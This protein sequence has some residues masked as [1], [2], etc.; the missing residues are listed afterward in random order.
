MIKLEGMSSILMVF[1]NIEDKSS[2]ASQ[3]SLRNYNALRCSNSV[4]CFNLLDH[5]EISILSKR[6]NLFFGRYYALSRENE[7]KI[8]ELCKNTDIVCINASFYGKLSKKI[9]QLFPKIKVITFFQNCEYK[10]IK[11]EQP[12]NL[13]AQ[14]VIKKNEEWACK[15]SDKIIVLNER[16]K[17]IIQKLYGR[18]ADAIIPISFPNKQI[19]FNKSEIGSPPT[20]LFLGSNF[21]ANIHG[22]KWFMKKVLPFVNIKLKI[23]GKDMDKA[24]L[25]KNDKLEVIGYIENLDECMQNTDFMV[26]P[27]FK[28]SG[29]KVK[30]CEALM[31]GKNIIGTREA[32]QGYDVDIEKVGACCETAEEFIRAINEFPSKFSNK[33]NE[34]SRSVFLEKYTNDVTFKQL[35]EV[36]NR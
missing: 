13:I 21:F 23:V 15:Y 12:Y 35:T 1:R 33:F 20:A 29:M 2:G 16:D 22:I 32:F 3:F 34:Y 4:V 30:T 26:F 8:L 10:Y 6:I 11:H 36:L 28:G 31:H 18:I 17:F 19:K 25:P 9:K 14:Y 7:Q 27:I 24:N 5:Y